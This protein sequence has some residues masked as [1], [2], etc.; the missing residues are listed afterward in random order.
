M[1]GSKDPPK[2]PGPSRP[3]RRAPPRPDASPPASGLSDPRVLRGFATLRAER[4]FGEAEGCAACA[5]ARL[6]DAREDALCD[7][8]LGQAL[9]IDGGWDLGA[10]GKRL[11]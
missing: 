10:P 4:V 5:E 2:P 9:G 11:K 3:Q 8:H 7:D 1:S 6:A